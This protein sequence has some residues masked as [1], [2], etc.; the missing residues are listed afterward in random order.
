MDKSIELLV[1][2]IMSYLPEKEREDVEFH[3]KNLF[4]KDIY[5]V[6]SSLYGLHEMIDE[7]ANPA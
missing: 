7:I 6:E 2:A 5:E 3:V 4:N 1:N